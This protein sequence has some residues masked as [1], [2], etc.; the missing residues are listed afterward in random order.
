MSSSVLRWYLLISLRATV[1]GLNLWGLRGESAFPAQEDGRRVFDMRQQRYDTRR[2][3]THPGKTG[4][5]L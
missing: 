4:Q 1:P 2:Q 3:A 5:V